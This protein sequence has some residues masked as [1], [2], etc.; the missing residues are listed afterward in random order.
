MDVELVANG[1][2]SAI[3]AKLVELGFELE[4]I[5][6]LPAEDGTT[7]II[8]AQL[9]ER[10]VSEFCHYIEDVVSPFDVTI[11]EAGMVQKAGMVRAP[12]V[13]KRSFV[14]LM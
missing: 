3:V 8:A 6:W 13:F 2:S 7:T 12:G 4:I 9:T 1:D 11:I 10:D 14:P 5:H